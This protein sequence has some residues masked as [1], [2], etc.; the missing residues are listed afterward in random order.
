MDRSCSAKGRALKRSDSGSAKFVTVFRKGIEAQTRKHIWDLVSS[1]AFLCARA[2][3]IEG[4]QNAQTQQF[5]LRWRAQGPNMS[6]LF[7]IG[8]WL[9]GR[10]ETA[11]PQLHVF[12]VTQLHRDCWKLLK[13]C[14]KYALLICIVSILQDHGFWHLLP[15]YAFL[16]FVLLISWC[17]WSWPT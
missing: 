7:S 14:W 11:H 6:C 15:F 2:R 9:H 4:T 8:A 1:L 10:F 16:T 12:M 5:T 13:I 3:K 17:H